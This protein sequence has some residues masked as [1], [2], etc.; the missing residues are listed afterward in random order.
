MVAPQLNAYT[1]GSTPGQQALCSQQQ[2]AQTLADLNN[3]TRGG[4]SRKRMHKKIYRGG[5]Q[6]VPTL[7]TP[8]PNA[9]STQNCTSVQ[10]DMAITGSQ[11]QENAIS[12][13]LGSPATGGS[14]RRKSSRNSRSRNRSRSSRSRKGRKGRKSRS[15]RT[16]RTKRH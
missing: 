6:V 16:K 9:S 13:K 14:K 1:C 15:R 10:R 3:I 5:D 12:D 2:S 4:K 7:S 8:Y 11:S